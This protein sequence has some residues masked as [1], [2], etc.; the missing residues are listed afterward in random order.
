MI[1]DAAGA[2]RLAR[3]LWRH[4]RDSAVLAR[5]WHALAAPETLALLV[6]PSCLERQRGSRLNYLADELRKA[7]QGEPQC[8]N[9]RKQEVPSWFSDV[10]CTDA[11]KALDVL[12]LAEAWANDC[13]PNEWSPIRPLL[14][15]V[16]TREN[17]LVF[18]GKAV[19]A[20][21]DMEV[22]DRSHVAPAMCSDAEAMRILVDVMKVKELGDD[23]WRSVLRESLKSIR[24][25]P[26]EACDADWTDLWRKMRATPEPIRQQ[27]IGESRSQIR[28]RRRDKS[29]VSADAVLLPGEF[30]FVRRCFGQPE[31]AR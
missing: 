8:P 24:N 31:G 2:L 29:W 28:V 25:Y 5:R 13:T 20:P 18:P 10:A 17:E 14:R 16:L 7:T 30:G 15:I 26:P 3:E 23:V 11:V 4:P 21:D 12:K 1:P 6:H 19:F 9:L 22:P 27:F